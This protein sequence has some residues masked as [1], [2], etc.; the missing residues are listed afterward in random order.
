MQTGLSE[1]NESN[2]MKNNLIELGTGVSPR[3]WIEPLIDEPK[4]STLSGRVQDDW[5]IMLNLN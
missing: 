2:F 3:F 5:F 4:R 1:F